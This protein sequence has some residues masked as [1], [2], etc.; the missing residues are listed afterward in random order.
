MLFDSDVNKND[1]N[2]KDNKDDKDNKDI[3]DDKPN[4]PRKNKK[5]IAE[6]STVNQFNAEDDDN[7]ENNRVPFKKYKFILNKNRNNNNNNNNNTDENE[8]ENEFLGTPKAKYHCDNSLCDHK[9][10]FIRWYGN[11]PVKIT[12]ANTLVDLVELGK[13]YHCRMRKFHNGIDL[14]VLFEI[15]NYLNELDSLIGLKDIKEEIV[16]MLIYLLVMKS[17]SNDKINQFNQ[18]KEKDNNINS[19]MLHAV[20]TGS[21]GTGKTT[22]IEILAKIY[23]KLGFLKKGHIVK[24]KRSDLI[25]KY[26]GHTAAQTQAK[27][28]EAKGGIL[29]IDEAYSLGNPEGRDSFSK[30]CIDTL[31]QALSENK[32]EFVCIIAGYKDSLDSSFFNY[33]E[34][35]RR[36]FPFRFDINKYTSD[37]LAQIFMKKINEYKFWEVEFTQEELNKLIGLNYK[38]FENQGGDMETLCLNLKIVQNKRV[39]LLPVLDKK[40]LLL[41]DVKESI[42]KFIFLKGDH[43]KNKKDIPFGLYV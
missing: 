8:E 17:Y 26:L 7:E 19:D 35:L 12:K 6:I 40:K 25:G 3:K 13:Y 2:N 31:N 34:G 37:E 32:S 43:I 28:N 18:D 20:I 38:Y 22:F 29:L 42:N 30:E 5:R 4:S 36:R 24:A 21:P 11:N 10:Y 16:N 9:K 14:K 39:F 1:N 41:T 15:S 23:T 33:N 27:I